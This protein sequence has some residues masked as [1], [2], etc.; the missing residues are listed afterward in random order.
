MQA[1]LLFGVIGFAVAV[2]AAGLKVSE[3]TIDYGTIKEGPPVIKDIILT[4]SGSQ[5]LIIANAAAS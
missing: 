3:S 4:N 1:I 5:P 2:Q